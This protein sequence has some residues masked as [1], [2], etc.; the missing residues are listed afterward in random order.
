MSFMQK[1]DVT[2]C[3]AIYKMKLSSETRFT[4]YL[5]MA[6]RY[7]C[8][9]CWREWNHLHE[10][11]TNKKNNY[12]L[13]ILFFLGLFESWLPLGSFGK[14]RV[15]STYIYLPWETTSREVVNTLDLNSKVSRISKRFIQSPSAPQNMILEF[16]S[17]TNFLLYE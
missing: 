5:L 7:S 3:K 2:K 17:L 13:I 12:F 1:R 14:M 11:D 8:C 10:Q 6:Q 4:F 16:L 9:E 15:P